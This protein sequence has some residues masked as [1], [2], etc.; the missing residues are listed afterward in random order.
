MPTVFESWTVCPHKP[1]EKLEENLWLVHG[2]MPKS[3]VR[4]VMTVSKRSDGG[5]LIHNAVALDAAEMAELEQFGTPAYLVVPNG[6][7][8][9]DVKIFKDRYPQAA[10]V[11]PRGARKRVAQVVP[12]EQTYD[13]LPNDAHVSLQHLQGVKEAEGVVCVKSPSGVLSLIF[14]DAVCN[15]PHH[16]GVNGFMMHPTGEPS[17]PRVM[18][19]LVVKDKAAFAGHLRQLAAMPGL[20]RLIFGHGAPVNADAA[21]TLR[22]AADRL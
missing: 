19:W 13:T 16:T 20:E 18:R 7:H 5:L 4:R 22:R 15:M 11:C 3:S 1:I 12:P 17:V 6:Y 10:V 2:T 9:M 21:A 14:N 8:R